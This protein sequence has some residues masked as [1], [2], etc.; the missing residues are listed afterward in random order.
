MKYNSSKCGSL[1]LFKAIPEDKNKLLADQTDTDSTLSAAAKSIEDNC[2]TLFNSSL[3][4][5]KQ[6]AP[7]LCQWVGNAYKKAMKKKPQDPE[8][9]YEYYP[10][11][12]RGHKLVK[13][14][15]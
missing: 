9:Q 15:K 1:N 13:I 3:S 4:P 2:L 7:G 11:G 8:Q 10:T 12:G 14:T 5:I 6:S